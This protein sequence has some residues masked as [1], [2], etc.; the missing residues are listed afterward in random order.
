MVAQTNHYVF[1]P[2]DNPDIKIWRYINFPK[3]VSFLQSR[4]LFFSR[5]DLLGDPYE[6]ATSHANLK[7]GPEMYKDIPLGS[8]ETFSSQLSDFSKWVRQWTFINCWHMNE[9]ES[10]AMWKLYT[11]AED[12]VAIQST[13]RRLCQCLPSNVMVGIVHYIDYET[14]WLPEDNIF[15]RFAHKR[16]SFEHERELRALIQDLPM[17]EKKMKIGL[18]NQEVGTLIPVGLK[19][20]VEQVYVSPTAEPWFAELVR[21]VTAKYEVPFKITQSILS[22]KPVF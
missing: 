13:Y 19:E 5:S 10:G 18:P 22:K 21:N 4:S 7:L 11:R 3:Y 2:P 15:W 1:Q 12:S 16:K 20:L 14:E 9:H 8:Y 6:G 17:T